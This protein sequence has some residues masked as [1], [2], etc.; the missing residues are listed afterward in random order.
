MTTPAPADRPQLPAR[1]RRLSLRRLSPGA[2]PTRCSSGPAARSTTRRRCTGSDIGVTRRRRVRAHLRAQPAL[3]PPD[4][5][6]RP[7]LQPPPARQI[8][9]FRQLVA[10]LRRAGVS[11][12][13]W[14]EAPRRVW[15][16]ISQPV[17]TLRLHA[18]H[19]IAS[20][21]RGATGDLV[22]WAQEHLVRRR[23]ADRDRRRL[24]HGD[25][26]RG[27]GASRPP[28]GLPY[29]RD[30]PADLVRAA[31]LPAGRRDLGAEERQAHR[32][33]HGPRRRRSQRPRPGLGLAA[34]PW[35]RAP[36]RARPRAPALDHRDPGRTAVHAEPTAG[37]LVGPSRA[38]GIPA[39]T[40]RSPGHLRTGRTAHR[41]GRINYS[42]SNKCAR[43][44][45]ARYVGASTDR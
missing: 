29:R 8:L 9:R 24:R 41:R 38:K 21:G 40:S 11:W 20:I 13:D 5:P 26:G 45:P 42:A 1:A 44:V 30:R 7:G 6:A 34:R 19:R 10:R 25:A 16:A 14:Q 27:R 17:G 33:R 18:G 2:S 36:G 23:P 32:R 28:T 15:R 35:P 22:V 12:W 3:R 4:L 43:S 31:A 39:R 37:E